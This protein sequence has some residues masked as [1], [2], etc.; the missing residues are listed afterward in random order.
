MI[1]SVVLIKPRLMVADEPASTVEPQRDKVSV[2]I[3][4]I[5]HDIAIV[6]RWRAHLDGQQERTSD[7]AEVPVGDPAWVR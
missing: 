4:Y 3:R 1:V 6:I 5:T 2:A 7:R